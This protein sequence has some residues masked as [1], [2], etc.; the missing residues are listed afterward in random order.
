MPPLHWL[1]ANAEDPVRINLMLGILSY[2]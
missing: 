1:F 2:S